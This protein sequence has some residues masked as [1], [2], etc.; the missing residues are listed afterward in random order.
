MGL[1]A[2]TGLSLGRAA[3]A[4]V[5]IM[6]GEHTHVGLISDRTYSMDGGT[7]AVSALDS[8]GNQLV[9]NFPD[10]MFVLVSVHEEL[11]NFEGEVHWKLYT[12]LKAAT[13]ADPLHVYPLGSQFAVNLLNVY[14]DSNNNMFFSRQ[15]AVTRLS[16]LR[17][18][19]WTVEI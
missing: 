5:E 10:A 15:N 14:T 19:V 2:S 12:D 18:T 1:L 13:S 3:S 11:T 4:L 6:A 16:N 7:D 8:E 17:L 9:A